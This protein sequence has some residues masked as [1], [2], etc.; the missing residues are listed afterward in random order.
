MKHYITTVDFDQI[1][2]FSIISE[3]EEI[4][5]ELPTKTIQWVEW[6][7][8][9]DD[10]MDLDTFKAHLEDYIKERF[11]RDGDDDGED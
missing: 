6:S 11:K 3:T 1:Y 5:E 7:V 9:V 8:M 4:I 2:G 10:A